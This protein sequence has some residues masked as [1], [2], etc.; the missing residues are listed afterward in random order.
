M[1]WKLF[2]SIVD[3]QP[4]AP[5]LLADDE[6]L[7]YAGLRT[8]ALDLAR[9]LRNSGLRPGDA[10]AIYLPNHPDFVVSVLAIWHEGAICLPLSTKYLEKE[11]TRYLT[12]SKAHVILTDAA[13]REAVAKIV[14]TFF[15]NKPVILNA[16]GDDLPLP[17]AERLAMAEGTAPAL[18][19]YSTGSTGQAKSVQRTQNQLHAEIV[20][21]QKA[22][23]VSAAD[24]ILGVAPL[25]H[26]HGFANAMLAALYSGG[27][28]VLL[29]AFNP[30]EAAKILAGKKITIFP[31]VPFIFKMLASLKASDEPADYSSLRLCFSAGAP[32]EAE[33]S[34][35]FQ[36]RYG[37][38]V[39][40]LYG[41]TETGSICL[42]VDADPSAT[43]DSVGRPMAGIEVAY[44][45]EE[46]GRLPAG[47]LGELGIRSPAMTGCYL[48]E[49]ELTARHFR[50]GWFLPGDL[51]EQDAEGRVFIRGRKT[52]FINVGGNKVDPAEVEKHLLTH[53]KV[54]D[55]AVVGRETAYG[56]HMV[57]AFV[58]TSGEV[59]KE[60][61]MQFCKAGLAEFKVPKAV[62]FRGEI[63]RSPLGK[64]LRKYLE[65]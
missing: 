62:E 10:A 61:L 6:T 45:N 46:G 42:N 21:Y 8:R 9:R 53:P 25:F 56:G 22:A 27:S 11:V 52:L 50:D 41:T 14:D 47:E 35:Q 37:Q 29:D 19:Q 7:S 38:P 28:M 64:I 31:G 33:I 54:A 36:Q 39:R 3:R 30:R 12:D 13:R 2:S 63:P 32:L 43:L 51:A 24:R 60:E 57:K 55:C 17:V 48:N 4:D 26:A 65:E 23:K 59:D 58:V 1:L 5:A 34:R 20:H 44:F 16:A 40:Q 15:D 49:P 18:W